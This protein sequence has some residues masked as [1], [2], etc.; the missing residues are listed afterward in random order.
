[1][2]L[3]SYIARVGAREAVA[4]RRREQGLA[5]S[6]GGHGGH[7]ALAPLDRLHRHCRLAPSSA[8]A[9]KGGLFFAYGHWVLLRAFGYLL[10]S[11]MAIGYCLEPL[12]TFFFFCL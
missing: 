12:G 9:S 6:Y 11:P 1:M 3:F 2:V 4:Y 10:F 5:A 7:A 8:H